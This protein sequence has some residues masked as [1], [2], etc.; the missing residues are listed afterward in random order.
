MGGVFVEDI[1]TGADYFVPVGAGEGF[2]KDLYVLGHHVDGGLV[3]V[4][5]D[6]VTIDVH[7]CGG[8]VIGGAA[9]AK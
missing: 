4:G 6:E 1:D 9:Q 8:G 5:D 7:H 3:G 2:G